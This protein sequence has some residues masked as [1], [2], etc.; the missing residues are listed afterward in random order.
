MRLCVVT[1]TYNYPPYLFWCVL[2]AIR[3]IICLYEYS[4]KSSAHS[5]QYQT[6]KAC[7]IDDLVINNKYVLLYVFLCT[8]TIR[9]KQ[10]TQGKTSPPQPSSFQNKQSCFQFF[11]PSPMT[12]NW[13]T[14]VTIRTTNPRGALVSITFY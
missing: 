4:Q 1:D 8:K 14:Y 11:H 13:S 5:Q 9:P 3:I 6:P 7:D 10:L 12:S 2:S